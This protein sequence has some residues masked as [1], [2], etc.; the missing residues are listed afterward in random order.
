MSYSGFVED[1]SPVSGVGSLGPGPF[2]A[3]IWN[4]TTPTELGM[5]PG[6]FLSNANAIN[7]AGQVVG[8]SDLDLDPYAPFHA[9]IWNG[10]TA[11]DLNSLLDQS[12]VGWT[13]EDATG[14]NSRGQIVG[15]GI[16]GSGQTMGFL[17]TPVSVPG[18]V[19]GAGLPGLILASCGLLGWWR[20]RRQ[21]A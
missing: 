13:L 5:L 11:I 21:P 1:L 3:T 16:D 9:T 17:L 4:G 10:T 7:N 12:G 20:R 15:Y 18:P 6:A 2:R 8:L 19:A 14:I